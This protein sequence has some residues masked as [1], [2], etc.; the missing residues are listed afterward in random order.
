MKILSLGLGAVALAVAV[1]ALA[2]HAGG[3][4]LRTFGNYGSASAG[5]FGLSLALW[6]WG[7]GRLHHRLPQEPSHTV[8]RTYTPPE[9]KK[10]A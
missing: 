5:L 1:V 4:S 6:P 3:E 2:Q 8:A 9:Q 7:H 10:T